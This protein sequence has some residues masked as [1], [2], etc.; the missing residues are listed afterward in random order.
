V[1]SRTPKPTPASET[2]AALA[3]LGR[4]FW[5]AAIRVVD[6]RLG[7]EERARQQTVRKRIRLTGQYTPQTAT[8]AP[9]TPRAP[10]TRDSN[11]ET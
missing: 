11:E 1:G 10:A 5:Q 3:S 2:Q 7:E 6:Q 4:I 8:N 9:L